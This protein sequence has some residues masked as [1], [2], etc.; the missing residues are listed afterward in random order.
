MPHLPTNDATAKRSNYRRPG[1]VCWS[2]LLLRTLSLVG[3]LGESSWNASEAFEPQTPPLPMPRMLSFLNLHPFFWNEI[4]AR[5]FIDQRGRS[6]KLVHNTYILKIIMTLRRPHIATPIADEDIFCTARPFRS[7][8][9]LLV[10]F[11]RA[12]HI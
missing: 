6:Q 4:L 11:R 2:S 10:P 9:T 1:G 7:W 8:A 3:T 12:N 5:A